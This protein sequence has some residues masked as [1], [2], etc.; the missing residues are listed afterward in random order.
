LFF[1][2]CGSSVVGC[3][4]GS[5][6][7]ESVTVG[8]PAQEEDRG[9]LN[10]AP[11]IPDEIGENP[12]YQAPPPP[13]CAD[14]EL[15]PDEACDDGNRNNGDGCSANC[16]VVEPGYACEPGGSCVPVAVCGDSLV[17]LGE[18]CDDG[19]DQGG[20]G[21]SSNCQ[22][23][24]GYVCP[25]PGAECVSSAVCGDAFVALGEECDD[26]NTTPGDGCSDTCQ[27][28]EGWLCPIP[29]AKC[30]PECGD[31]LVVGSERC[32]DG[33]LVPGDGCSPLCRLEAGFACDVP[34]AGCRQTECQD[35]I[36][37]GSEQCD[38]GNDVPYD[39]C[40]ATCTNE[41]RCGLNV[42]GDY[43][44][45]A[46][47]GDGMKFGEEACDD[48]NTLPDDGCS[49]TC[50]REDGYA[51]TND[52]ADL[53]D[54]LNLPIIYRDFNSD[55]PQFEVTPDAAG[56]LGVLAQ[57]IVAQQL[58]ANGK[59]A[60]NAAFSLDPDG[61]GPVTARA[62]TMD[63]RKPADGTGAAPL[64]NAAAIAD[65]FNE[66]YTDSNQSVQVVDTLPLVAI[67]N[68]SFQFSAT[69]ATQFFPIDGRGG[70][71]NSNDANGDPHNFHFTSEVRQWFEFKGGEQLTF[72]GDDDVWVF[73]NGQLTVD[74]GGIHSELSGSITLSDDGQNSTLAIQQ[75]VG[76]VPVESTIDVP[77]TTTGVNEIV[78]FQ[79]ERHVTA[80]NYT[81]TL[82]GFN[83]PV[84]SCVSVC[85]DGVLTP[86]ETCDEGP[87][88]G[89]G[90]G[91]C[92]T[93]CTPGPRCGDAVVNGTE[94]C[95]NGFNQ[96]AYEVDASSCAP[97]CVRASHCGD[98]VV[99][100]R[101][102]EQCDDGVN[103]GSYNGCSA[104]C[105]L[106]PRCGD[107][108]TN[109][110]ETCDDGNRRNGDGCNSN[111]RLERDPA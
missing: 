63:G 107:K 71:Q 100:G 66:W 33:N 89:T 5:S 61:T 47:C 30:T 22:I 13:D 91:H 17:R 43:V 14:F 110:D 40:T 37:E 93:D 34:G 21:C 28:E 53:G 81:L 4:P 78:V 26:D 49:P 52:A 92:N 55:H 108:V 25:T 101:F 51:C 24:N 111:C 70:N 54:A 11:P 73:V 41:P 76:G 74:L 8:R 97:G 98:A 42:A 82:Q 1:A 79:A 99:D 103:D 31:G 105:Q 7:G 48:G 77:V 19:N 32:D 67:G 96:D 59:P 83:A 57:G 60:Y 23:E 85:G 35:Q 50:E 109:G 3:K 64:A 69:G 104:D 95:D 72:T 44:C 29:G 86:D 9:N 10:P 36:K 75:A 58:G 62:W 88:N 27:L 65:R 6:A 39:G 18:K 15:G 90:Y 84:T 94:Q 2:W 20:D 102:N 87:L 45:G 68:D 38:D 12:L 56:V 16:L 106:G 80:S 46:V